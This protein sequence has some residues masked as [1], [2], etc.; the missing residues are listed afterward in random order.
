[1]KF[2]KN[3]LSD[4][5]YKKFL[6][7]SFIPFLVANKDGIVVESNQAACEL[8]NYSREEMKGV[9]SG[10]II[11]EKKISNDTMNPGNG[12]AK[13]FIEGFGFKK[14]GEKFSIEYAI[15]TDRGNEE[16]STAFV[17]LK[18]PTYLN[19]EKYNQEKSA[20][21]G[22]KSAFEFSRL[23]TEN[24]SSGWILDQKSLR[25]LV[26]SRGLQILLML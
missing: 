21:P 17:I 16:F 20:D 13:P 12:A 2:F 24:P 26:R 3:P 10:E 22:A 18:H 19:G 6:D 11:T 1:M 5:N 15:Q 25:I 4:L 14:C 23:F 8:F 9:F 7:E